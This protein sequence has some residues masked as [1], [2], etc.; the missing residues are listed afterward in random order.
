V[1]SLFLETFFEKFF[2]C[3]NG[4]GDGGI[5]WK[6]GGMVGFWAKNRGKP[7]LPRFTAP[8]TGVV[9]PF[10]TLR[11]GH[12]TSPIDVRVTLFVNGV[13]NASSVAAALLELDSLGRFPVYGR[14]CSLLPDRFRGFFIRPIC[15]FSYQS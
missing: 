15:A 7:D 2:D 10:D 6:T 1:L 14:R 9:N 11:R 5:S 8:M 3:R 4:G 12:Y 13:E